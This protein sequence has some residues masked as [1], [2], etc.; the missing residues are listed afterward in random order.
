MWLIFTLKYTIFTLNQSA[1]HEF[2]TLPH[3][4]TFLT[5]CVWRSKDEESFH[6]CSHAKISWTHTTSF[7][8]LAS[9][10]KRWNLGL[11]LHPPPLNKTGN[12]P[13]CHLTTLLPL[14]KTGNLPPCHLTTLPSFPPCHLTTFPLLRLCHLTILPP[15][16]PCHL[17]PL[18]H[19]SHLPSTPAF[20][21]LSPHYLPTSPTVPPHY[22][23]TFPTLP[24]HSTHT[25]FPP[26]QHTTLP[27]FPTHLSPNEVDRT[28]TC[29]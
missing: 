12:L 23:P 9:E 1:N 29:D 14:N 4:A 11:N 18:I 2:Q 3:P 6:P 16:P 24:P 19:L 7:C 26:S 25:P 20:P 28:N 17:T 5:V 10:T 21:K 8:W 13:P 22:S 15:F 27:P